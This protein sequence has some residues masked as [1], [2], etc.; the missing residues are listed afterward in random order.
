MWHVWQ[1]QVAY[2]KF[3]FKYYKERDCMVNYV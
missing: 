3:W 1:K 2:T